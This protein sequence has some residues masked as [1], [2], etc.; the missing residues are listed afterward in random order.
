ML[1]LTVTIATFK[2]AELLDLVLSEFVEQS[3]SK[4]SQEETLC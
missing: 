1:E 2:R 3:I 4:E